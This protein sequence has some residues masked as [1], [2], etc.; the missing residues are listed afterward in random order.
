MFSLSK[1]Q[2][3]AGRP[4]TSVLLT[5][6]VPPYRLPLYKGLSGAFSD[7]RILLSTEMEP[8]RAWPVAWDGLQVTVQRALTV[9]RT[10]KHRLGFSE[11][12]YVHVPYDTLHLLRRH[13]P[14]VVISAELGARTLQ[15]ALYR[16]LNPATRLIVWACVSEHTEQNRGL[17][18]A[19]LRRWLLLQA[20]A[21]LVNGQSGAR[22]IRGFG[23]PSEKVFFAPY[24]TDMSPW[25]AIPLPREPRI[26]QRL[27]FVG[28][29][30]AV[31]GLFPF[32]LA[33]ARWSAAH[34]ER[35]AELW[36]V[37]DGPCRASLQALRLPPNI[38]VRW[39]GNTS[40][41]QLPELYAQA[42]ILA[43]PTLSDE[44][45]VVVNEAMA[46]GLPVLGSVYSQA[47]EELV[48]DGATGWTFRPD[49]PSE[50]DAALD[51]ALSTR[52]DVL[53]AMREA[54]RLRVKD[55]TPDTV[56][57]RILQAVNYVCR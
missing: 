54:S 16:K 18:R 5:N 3:A 2:G 53:Q 43:F 47:V 24:T 7:F 46:A 13:R 10:W 33:L 41:Q 15:A 9:S 31:K 11:T 12:V 50:L 51:R 23:V 14:D 29:L 42:G 52:S 28:R 22:Y 32:L 8:S 34:P 25:S 21:V 19:W 39:L 40:Y 55:L 56:R 26:A 6:F 36:V 38:F 4:Q 57:D 45:G 20:D 1:N 17:L 48:V 44:W 27:L 30:V 37:G 49:Q 35:N